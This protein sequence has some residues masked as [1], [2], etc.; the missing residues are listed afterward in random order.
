LENINSFWFD[1]RG[2]GLRPAKAFGELQLLIFVLQSFTPSTYR[3]FTDP[4]QDFSKRAMSSDWLQNRLSKPK[5]T[6]AGLREIVVFAALLFKLNGGESSQADHLIETEALRHRFLAS[7]DSA[8][9][10]MQLDFVLRRLG[11]GSPEDN[12]AEIYLKRELLL[13]NIPFFTHMDIYKLT[14]AIFWLT[15]MGQSELSLNDGQAKK[16][17]AKIRT[18]VVHAM[19]V[20]NWDLLAELLLCLLLIKA[21]E[22]PMDAYAIKLLLSNVHASGAWAASVQELDYFVK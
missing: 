6:D 12:V 22:E 1:K 11:I 19:R 14:H 3:W 18:L 15:S 13:N 9:S 20:Q 10:Q 16:L 4:T 8:F 5:A 7:R 17:W 21:P 2:E